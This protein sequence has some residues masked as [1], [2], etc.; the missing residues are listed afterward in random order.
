MLLP[1]GSGA[2]R[3]H[4]THVTPKNQFVYAYHVLSLMLQG[5]VWPKYHFM[6]SFR[7]DINTEMTVLIYMYLKHPQ[8]ISIPNIYI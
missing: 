5:F 2:A 4:P 8:I 7:P 6:A 3:R 1:M